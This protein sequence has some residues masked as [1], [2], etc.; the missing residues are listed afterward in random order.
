VIKRLFD[1][2][3]ATAGLLLLWPVLLL[4]AIVIKLDSRGPVFYRGV[5][6]GLNGRPFRIFK[7]RT[8]VP[9]AE[10]I[11]S[12]ATARYDPRITRVG[13]VLRRYKVD[14]F[15][16]LF[17]VLSGEMS[18][19]GPRPEVEEHTSVYTDE[20]KAILS[21][22]PGIT[23]FASIHF[24]NLGE[25]LGD[26]DANAVFIEKYRGEKNRLRLEYVRKRSFLVD[27]KIIFETLFR[28]FVRR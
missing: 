13:R 27:M 1:V 23:D 24:R 8:M 6:T 9:N 21:V 17:N 22:K 16:Q 26:E 19:V 14:E 20:E 25:M 3:A 11:G 2:V 4:I 28:V 12:T 15:P 10:Q 7:F 5:R 18:F